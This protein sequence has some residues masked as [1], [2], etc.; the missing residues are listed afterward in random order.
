MFKEE[1]EKTTHQQ[2]DTESPGDDD[3]VQQKNP[4]NK[5]IL[6][7][8]INLIPRMGKKQSNTNPEK[9]QNNTEKIKLMLDNMRDEI[10][11]VLDTNVHRSLEN[12]DSLSTEAQVALV[13][14]WKE[15]R[16]FISVFTEWIEGLISS[17]IDRLLAGQR[18]DTQA[19]AKAL[20]GGLDAVFKKLGDNVRM[21]VQP[22]AEPV[23]ADQP[24][25]ALK[26]CDEEKS[27]DREMAGGVTEQSNDD[28]DD[29]MT[30]S[31]GPDHGS[32]GQ[33]N[34]VNENPSASLPAADPESSMG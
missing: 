24:E 23:F 29:V 20:Q 25:Q 13:E 6:T 16:Q 33:A 11:S 34:N 30:D 5:T 26:D 10:H 19:F 1:D 18:L 4:K 21:T 22:P 31:V 9:T 17:I 2:Q 27:V 3:E 14:F 8:L 28:E 32:I 12:F 7:S 15:M